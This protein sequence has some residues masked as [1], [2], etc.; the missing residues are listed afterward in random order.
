MGEKNALGMTNLKG[1]ERSFP[2]FCPYSKLRTKNLPIVK[3]QEIICVKKKNTKI[4]IIKNDLD[5]I[6]RGT[7]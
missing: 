6:L 2:F 3:E 4:F 1:K 7:Y 5:K